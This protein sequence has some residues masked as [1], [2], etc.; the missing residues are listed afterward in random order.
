MDLRASKK[1]KIVLSG[2]NRLP[3]LTDARIV[4]NLLRNKYSIDATVIRCTCFRKLSTNVNRP[5]LQLVTLSSG[6]DARA[7]IRTAKKLRTST[8]DYV[9]DHVFFNTKLI[10]DQRKQDYDLRMEFKKTPYCGENSIWYVI[11][12][13]KMHTKPTWATAFAAPALA[14]KTRLPSQITSSTA[15]KR[16]HFAL[17]NAQSV[18]NKPNPISDLIDK[19]IIEIFAL[20]ESWYICITDL[21]LQ[22]SAPVGYSI[23]DALRPGYSGLGRTN[24]GGIAIIYRIVFITRLI[25]FPTRPMS[26]KLLICFM[27]AAFG[28]LILATKYRPSSRN[29]IE[30][31]FEKFSNLF[32]IAATYKTATI[33]SGVFNI[34][35]NGIKTLR[36][37]DL[38][39]TFGLEQPT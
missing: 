23:V 15:K 26:L 20:M 36:F 9:R 3:P 24:H 21:P 35:E 39:D 12:N 28:K 27:N 32:E 13:R 14:D 11:R 18:N 17:L 30:L 2:V 31:F 38:L 37:I 7:A 6:N 34:H 10:L 33:I 8:D 19:N 5:S 29:V 22:R 25:T 1:A 4:T 16:L